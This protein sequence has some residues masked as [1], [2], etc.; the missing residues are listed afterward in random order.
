MYDAKKK[1]GA[2]YNTIRYKRK[3][4]HKITA[5]V[6]FCESTPTEM[7]DEEKAD[8]K[9][10]FKTCR[11]PHNKDAL[12]SK[13]MESKSYRIEMIANE[14]DDYKEIWN[15]YF[16]CPDLVCIQNFD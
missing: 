2:L 6:S 7:T 13:L 4:C 10:F 9:L 12:K 11:L 1:N 3:K 14:F 8:L 15:F 5:E 16:V